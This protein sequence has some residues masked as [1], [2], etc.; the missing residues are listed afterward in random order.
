MNNK[1][2]AKSRVEK[3]AEAEVAVVKACKTHMQE[4]VQAMTEKRNVAKAKK[5][6]I[7]EEIIRAA[8]EAA[9]SDLGK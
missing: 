6:L 5:R 7:E 9:Y 3:R 2:Q 8:E 4:K 1:A